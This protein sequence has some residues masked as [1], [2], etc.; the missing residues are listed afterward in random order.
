L[1]SV[2][3][4]LLRQEILELSSARSTAQVERI[5][6]TVEFEV[7][8]SG[9]DPQTKSKLALFNSLMRSLYAT[10]LLG[11]NMPLY[12]P[13]VS[14]GRIFQKTAVE[15]LAVGI[16]IVVGLVSVVDAFLDPNCTQTCQE[17]LVGMGVTMIG[18]GAIICCCAENNYGYTPCDR[19]YIP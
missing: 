15:T 1:T 5:C 18:A 19:E 12:Y 7:G 6:S 10:E 11:L 4:R 8:R 9:L 2:E 3:K 17:L 14:N 16:L 13:L